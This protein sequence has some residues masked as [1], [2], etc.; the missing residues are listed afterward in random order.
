MLTRTLISCALLWSTP[1]WAEESF[2]S[3]Y[4]SY[5]DDYAHYLPSELEAL[6]EDFYGV[7]VAGSLVEVLNLSKTDPNEITVR[8]ALHTLMYN[9]LTDYEGAKRAYQR[10]IGDIATGTLT[11]GQIYMLLFREHRA[12]LSTELFIALPYYFGID[13]RETET[14]AYLTATQVIAHPDAKNDVNFQ[15]FECFTSGDY[16]TRIVNKIRVGFDNRNMTDISIDF[17]DVQYYKITRWVG[18]VIEME[19]ETSPE[20]FKE[21]LTFNFQTEEFFQITKNGVDANCTAGKDAT[22]VE[23]L[24]QP[25]VSSFVNGGPI[26][27]AQLKRLEDEVY[28]SFSSDYRKQVEQ[29]AQPCVD[30]VGYLMLHPICKKS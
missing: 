13:Q 7:N 3:K 1:S 30:E 26:A 5:Y 18:G 23:R 29:L 6:G 25:L 21:E 14:I 28:Q 24:T 11:V 12:K 19:P 16:C 2:E 4:A 9:G 27:E 10:D 20:C 17:G 15:R 22:P 8:T